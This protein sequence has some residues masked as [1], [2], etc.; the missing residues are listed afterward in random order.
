MMVKQR[1]HISRL[2]GPYFESW[3]MVASSGAFP[4]GRELKKRLR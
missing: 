4:G 1:R 3:I 2:Y